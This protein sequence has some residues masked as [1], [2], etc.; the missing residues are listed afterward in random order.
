MPCLPGYFT[1]ILLSSK[2]DIVA[3]LYLGIVE[4]T[5]PP[6]TNTRELV[7]FFLVLKVIPLTNCSSFLGVWVNSI[8]G[9]SV[10]QP[11]DFIYNKVDWKKDVIDHDVHE[12]FG[13]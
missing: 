5:S 1:Q 11:S 12:M 8:T 7:N 10:P 6:S 13:Y 4:Y 3:W 9:N 2:A